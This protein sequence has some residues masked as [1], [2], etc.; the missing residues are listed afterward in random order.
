[1]RQSFGN[2]RFHRTMML[3]S[4]V[5]AVG[6]LIASLFTF[7]GNG[8]GGGVFLLAVGLLFAFWSWYV[9]PRRLDHIPA[10]RFH[11]RRDRLNA[12]FSFLK[13]TWAVDPEWKDRQGRAGK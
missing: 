7:V 9:S 8:P 4:G 1:M 6:F 11:R 12:L 3:L 13:I 10:D 2:P 5:V